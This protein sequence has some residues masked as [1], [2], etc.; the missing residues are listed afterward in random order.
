V[1]QVRFAVPTGNVESLLPGSS[2][3]SDFLFGGMPQHRKMC[4]A[5]SLSSPS[6]HELVD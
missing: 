3:D 4:F 6:G 5:P 1:G 2:V